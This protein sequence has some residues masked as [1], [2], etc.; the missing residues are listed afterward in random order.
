MKM[1]ALR[2]RLDRKRQ[3]QNARRRIM[4]DPAFFTEKL[5]GIKVPSY[6]RIP[7]RPKK[8]RGIVTGEA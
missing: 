8:L 4:R 1:H 5:L 7:E 3:E 2:R 6:L